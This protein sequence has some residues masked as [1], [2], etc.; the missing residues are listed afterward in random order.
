LAAAGLWTTPSDLALFGMSIQATLSGR[1]GNLLTSATAEKMLTPVKNNY[2]LGFMIAGTGKGAWF[3]HGGRNRGFDTLFEASMTGKCGFAI[4]VNANC[5][6]GFLE[7]VKAAACQ[8]FGWT[9]PNPM[10]ASTYQSLS[11]EQLNAFA[12]SYALGELG[13]VVVKR[14]GFRLHC[15]IGGTTL[16]VLT[17]KTESEFD[18]STVKATFK[19]SN[20]TLAIGARKWSGKKKAGGLE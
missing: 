3:G 9:P 7:E 20:L 11:D 15:T 19:D 10:K 8:A 5:D 4:M 13:S 6:T 18:G 14:N 1:K 17:P 2:G 16:I 12:G